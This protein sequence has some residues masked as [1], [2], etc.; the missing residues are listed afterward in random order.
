[1]KKRLAVLSVLI[2]VLSLLCVVGNL[3]YAEEVRPARYDTVIMGHQVAFIPFLEGDKVV[4]VQMVGDFFGASGI[5]VRL[6]IYNC[7]AFSVGSSLADDDLQQLARQIVELFDQVDKCA[8]VGYNGATGVTSDIFRYNEAG[9]GSELEISPHTYQ[10]LTYAREMYDMTDGAFNPAVYRLV[11]L[12]GFSSRVYSANPYGLPAQPYDRRMD[13]NGHYDSLPD[14]KYIEAF[15]RPSFVDFSQNAVE[16][17]QRDGKY[18]VTKNVQPVTVDGVQ[19]EQ[20]LDLGGIAKGYATDL[21]K[22]LLVS[23]GID[24][25]YINAGTSSISLG[26]EYDGGK[27]N[28]GIID[29]LDE[30]SYLYADTLLSVDVEDRSVSTSGQY[31]RRYTVDGVEYAHIIDGSRGAPAQTGVVSVTVIAPRDGF[32]ATKGDCL[33]TALTVMGAEGAVE[34]INKMGDELQIVVQYRSADGKKQ[35]LSNIPKQDV[36]AG[37][38]FDSYAWALLQHDDGTF[39]Y[40]ADAPADRDVADY[41]WLLAVLGSVLGVV[42]VGIVV[43]RFV[44][45]KKTTLQNVTNARKDKP[46]K[47]GDVG[48]YLAV[49]LL[50]AVLFVAFLGKPNQAMQ[51]V[52]VVDEQMQETLFVYD[53]PSGRYQQNDNSVNGWQIDVQRADSGLTVTFSRTIDGEEHYNVMYISF[54]RNASVVMKDAKCGFHQDCVRT[55]GALDRSGGAIV[56]SPNRLTILTE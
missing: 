10:M 21:V 19:F 39:Y 33:T 51:K 7:D 32:W 37:E 1:M 11:D 14:E 52:I 44:H 30:T 25:Y 29:A 5:S 48:V 34:F 17:S 35:I 13:A 24:R 3:A 18:Y 12:W 56:C 40:K 43:Y 47:L 8:N 23:K 22:D 6:D 49:V 50:V 28:L 41:T 15:S 38:N 20:W 16:L 26:K 36:T 9:Y 31:N 46:F 27:Q 54:G 2:I 55:F 45:S 4:G 53:V 42:L